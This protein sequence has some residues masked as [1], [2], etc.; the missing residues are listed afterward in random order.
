[1]HGDC[2]HC[3][4]SGS[5]GC[6]SADEEALLLQVQQGQHMQPT[7]FAEYQ[8]LPG[9][10]GRQKQRQ[11]Q[12]Q[13]GGMLQLILVVM[14]CVCWLGMSSATILINKHIMVDLG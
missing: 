5:D 11:R 7:R 1:L 9:S 8:L 10:S 2:E 6:C 12:Q 13:C 14:S 3:F 4:S